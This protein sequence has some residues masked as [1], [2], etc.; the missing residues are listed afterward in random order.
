V[1]NA[2]FFYDALKMDGRNG[3][4]RY[5]GTMYGLGYLRIDPISLIKICLVPHDPV[6]CRPK[7]L[8]P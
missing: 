1:V 8:E 3:S 5:V 2:N 7:Q 6:T 4:H